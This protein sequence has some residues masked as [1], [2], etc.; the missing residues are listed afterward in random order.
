MIEKVN[1]NKIKDKSNNNSNKKE[2]NQI[3]YRIMIDDNLST[4]CIEVIEEFIQHF[5]N[6]NLPKKV[7]MEI[8]K[9]IYN[10]YGFDKIYYDYF[11][12][13]INSN[14]FIKKESHISITENMSE[15]NDNYIIP[16]EDNSNDKKLN[17]LVYSI[18]NI[19]LDIK[20]YLNVLKLNKE[21]YKFLRKVVYKKIL[22]NN[23]NIEFNKKI[24]IWKI[25]L[26]YN[27]NKKL[28][29]Y[30]ELKT[31]IMQN[32]INPKDSD[33]INVDV[34]RTN[35][36]QNKE[37]NQKKISNILKAVVEAIPGIS[38]NQGMNYVAAFLF[39]ILYLKKSEKEKDENEEETF[40]LFLG[41]FT[42]T[43][44]GELFKNN[45][46]LLK[47]FYFILER[48]ISIFIP[49]LYS[50]FQ[51]NNIKISYFITSWFVT[52]FTN[53]SQINNLNYEF[54]IL[55]KILDFFF[56]YGWKSIFVTIIVLIKNYEDKIMSLKSGELLTFL[57]SDINK[58]TFFENENF[59]IFINEFNNFKIDEELIKRIEKEFD[60]KINNPKLSK[61]L[62]F[63]II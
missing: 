62:R 54:K 37:L 5:L 47:K 21:Y 8:I 42:S 25:I 11:I 13:E 55:V 4:Y 22:L 60:M 1:N 63:Q 45:L 53:I 61:N 16:K 15:N 56:F 49:E 24:K 39:N 41:L 6:F 48:L 35:V 36:I 34:M 17:L 7:S 57:N 27:E 19:D 30:Q 51:N 3:I 12:D 26:D 52:L 43:K 33:I 20:D 10:K 50:F 29:N 38:Y 46:E 28:Y 31:K 23:P 40:Y 9:E 44:Y 59:D 14:T 2:E 18:Y 32:S 58:G